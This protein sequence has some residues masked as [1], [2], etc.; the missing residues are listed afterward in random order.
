[1]TA[2]VHSLSI[3]RV[4]L[5]P[6]WVGPDIASVANGGSR[7]ETEPEAV[8]EIPAWLHHAVAG[9]EH[10]DDCKGKVL[11][12]GGLLLKRVVAHAPFLSCLQGSCIQSLRTYN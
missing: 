3:H 9:E 1:M 5:S 7:L 4:A 8:C 10:V 12:K 6:I 11:Q 2:D